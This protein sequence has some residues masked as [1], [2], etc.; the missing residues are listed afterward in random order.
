MSTLRQAAQAVIDRWDSPAWKDVP[1]TAVYIADLRTALAAPPRLTDGDIYTLYIEVTNQ[2][3]RPRDE[4]IALGF[5]R[6]IERSVRKQIGVN[7][8]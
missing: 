3:L 1:A 5:A 4:R 7:C 2:T 6:A 8:E